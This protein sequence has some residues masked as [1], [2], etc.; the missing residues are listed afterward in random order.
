[1]IAWQGA[2]VS[3]WPCFRCGMEFRIQDKPAD[4]GEWTWCAEPVCNVRYWHADGRW[5]ATKKIPRVGVWPDP[6]NAAED[7]T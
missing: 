5:G 6:V 3:R 2:E 1:M 4:V 7:K